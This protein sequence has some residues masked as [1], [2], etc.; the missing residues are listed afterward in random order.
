MK[1]IKEWMFE[2]YMIGANDW[3]EIPP[4]V[5]EEARTDFEKLWKAKYQFIDDVYVELVNKLKPE[6]LDAGRF[7]S[8]LLVALD[9]PMKRRLEEKR[10]PPKATEQCAE[11]GRS[12][13]VDHMYWSAMGRL[14]E[15]DEKTAIEVT[16]AQLKSVMSEEY[17]WASITGFY[18]GPYGPEYHYGYADCVAHHKEKPRTPFELKDRVKL[19]KEGLASFKHTERFM[20]ENT[21]GMVVGYSYLNLDYIQV[22][23][24]GIKQVHTYHIKFWEKAE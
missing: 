5:A 17:C 10:Q 9:T 15:R 21:R 4:V 8:A 23:R 22:K 1:T 12:Q 13:A 6:P 16:G 18:D 7:L 20:N 24:D 11:C 2:W 14:Y 19:S 3:A